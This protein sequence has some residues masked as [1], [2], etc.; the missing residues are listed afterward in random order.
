MLPISAGGTHHS[1]PAEAGIRQAKGHRCV[2]RGVV[3]TAARHFMERALSLYGLFILL[4]YF[5]R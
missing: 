3:K 4:L 5:A 2:K 1:M